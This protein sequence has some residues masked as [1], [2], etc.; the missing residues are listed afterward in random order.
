MI[1]T[2]RKAEL[3]STLQKVVNIVPPRST[4]P[5]L[6]NLCITINQSELIVRA[7][8]LDLSIKVKR[9]LASSEGETEF[10]VNANKLFAI[11]KE[12]PESDITLDFADKEF[13]RISTANDKFKLP[14]QTAENFPAAPA[15][16]ELAEFSIRAGTLM[17]MAARVKF[18]VAKDTTRAALKGILCELEGD[19]VR[20]VA[21]DGHKLSM[22]NEQ[23]SAGTVAKN[24]S[25]ILPPKALDQ[26]SK[27]IQN[28]EE[29]IT[30]KV[31]Q[32]YAEFTAGE[33]VITSKLIEGDYPNYNE[34]IP[35]NTSKT[36]KVRRDD[37]FS[38]LRR[39]SVM[40]NSRTR[41]IRFVFKEN[42]LQI[43]SSDRDFRGE[44]KSSL[45]MQFEGEPI[46]IGFNADFL[47]EI[48]RLMDD[49][50][51]SITMNSPLSAALLKPADEVKAG[52][53]LFLIMPL[54]LLD[55]EMNE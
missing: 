54:R 22:C 30:V 33:T 18:A 8:D 17:D 43:S 48:L 49:D 19:S 1:V 20:M 29:T 11:V 38:V 37:L 44:G 39:I 55:D 5:I 31:G 12:M 53:M 41:Q 14:I 52:R 26:I 2:I 9:A 45:P 7:T 15:F 25:I 3:L 23:N 40:S 34:A 6:S 21:T 4:L 35:K 50:N 16:K 28:Y 27:T 13:V 46:T 42:E 36:A 32:T 51:V 24:I 10:I 47:I